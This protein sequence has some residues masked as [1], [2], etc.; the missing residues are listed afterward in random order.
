MKVC[1][2]SSVPATVDERDG[3]VAFPADGVNA[4]ALCAKKNERIAD[5]AF[6]VDIFK[7][8][9]ESKTL[10]RDSTLLLPRTEFLEFGFEEEVRCALHNALAKSDG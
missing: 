4:D 10:R 3:R 8:T 5:V 7:V 6:I 2:I 9:S 1:L